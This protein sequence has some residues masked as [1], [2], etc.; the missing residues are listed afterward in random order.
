MEK[1]SNLKK[2]FLNK[3]IGVLMGGVSAER[4]ISLN[5]GQSVLSALQQKGYRAVAVDVDRDVARTLQQNGIETAFIALHGRLGE[6]GSIQG[7]LE[8]EGIPYTGSGV[9]SSAIAMNKGVAKQIFNGHRLPTPVFQIFDKTTDAAAALKK[10]IT[11]PLPI[12]IKPTEEGSTIGIS[13]V[14]N[15]ADLDRAIS[16][17]LACS[18]EILIEQF[19]AGQE[20]TAAIINGTALPLIEI[21]PKSGFYDYQSKYTTG[22]TEYIVAPPMD[23]ALENKIQDLA[24]KAYRALFCCG[25]ARVDFMLANDRTP[26]ILEVNTIPGMTETSL[27]PK[28]AEKAGMDFGNL[29]ENILLQAKLH[30]QQPSF[31]EP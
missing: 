2:A 21:K 28:A 26:Y 7:L 31:T 12:V 15:E 3:K 20:L 9:L 16:R 30:K 24:L 29:V 23:K 17:A 10:M 25:A 8:V 5:T 13:I 11:L 22:A 27:L 6:D 14:K 4:N 1:I 18:S 19:I